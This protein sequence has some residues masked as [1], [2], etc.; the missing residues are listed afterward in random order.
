MIWLGK[1][2]LFS[3]TAVEFVLKLKDV[4]VAPASE[5][6]VAREILSV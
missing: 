6:R 1:I 3:R 2:Y 5:R 4:D